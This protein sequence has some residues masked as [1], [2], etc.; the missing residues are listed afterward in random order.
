MRQG[1]IGMRD[2]R[3]PQSG[4]ALLVTITV[5][6]VV[7]AIVSEVNRNTRDSIERAHLTL[8]R[9][10]LS[11]MA[12]SGIHVG[13]A[14]LMEDKKATEIDTIQEAWADPAQIEELLADFPMQD[15]TIT[16]AIIDELGKIQVNALVSFPEGKEFNPEQKRLWESALN[17]LNPPDESVDSLGE[18]SDIINCIKDWI[19]SGDDD[20]TEGINGV[21]SEYYETLIPPY[22][23][24]NGPLR[25]IDELGLIKGI[26]QEMLDRVEYGYRFIDQITV[27]GMEESK[28]KSETS[29]KKTLFTYPGKININTADLPVIMAL[30]PDSKS[31]LENSVAAQA[32]YDYRGERTEDGFVNNLMGQWYLKCPGCEDSGIKADLITTKS[33]VFSITCRAQSKDTAVTVTAVIQREDKNGKYRVLSWKQD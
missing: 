18:N 20:A 7:F 12:T 9:N 10:R 30:L 3:N 21:E 11:E 19:D 26:T 28:T 1:E 14:L 17:M 8:E 25:S 32:I 22:K 5:L 2:Q 33:D 16:M 13:I 23:A 6:F 15:G 31:G 24:S 29:E 4:V 27:Y